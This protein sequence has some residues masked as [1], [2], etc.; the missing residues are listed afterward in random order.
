MQLVLVPSNLDYLD[1]GSTPV[2]QMNTYPLMLERGRVKLTIR[3]GRI[4][5]SDR[6]LRPRESYPH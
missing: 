1:S 6:A 3:T 2:Q 5:C 4:V